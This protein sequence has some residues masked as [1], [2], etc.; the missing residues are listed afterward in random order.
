MKPY[1]TGRIFNSYQHVNNLVSSRAPPTEL[2]WSKSQPS[3]YSIHKY[4]SVP[5][6]S[7]ILFSSKSTFFAPMCDTGA[8]PQE[9]FS[10]ASKQDVKPGL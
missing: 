7:L 8:G 3:C 1:I 6:I 9:Y 10:F 2:F 4:F 5:V